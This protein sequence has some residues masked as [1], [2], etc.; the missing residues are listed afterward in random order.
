[1]DNYDNFFNGINDPSGHTPVY[2]TPENSGGGN[3]RNKK[4]TLI[5]ALLIVIAVIMCIAVVANVI[6]L[7]SMKKQVAQEYADGMTEAV[8]EE[9]LNAIAE[10]LDGKEISDDILAQ[11]EKDVID[12]LNTSAAAVAGTETVYSTV[13]IVATG[14]SDRSYGS[15]FLI[16][17]KDETT[18][19]TKRYVITNAHVV[20]ETVSE[21]TSTG[22]GW[23]FGGTTTTYSFRVRE[24][25]VCSLMNGESGTYELEE[26]KVGSYLEVIG[27]SVI[28][29]KNYT[30]L[31][32]LAILTF[33]D[34]APDEEKYPSLNISAEEADYGESIAIVGYPAPGS[35]PKDAILSLSTGIISA[36][37]H[38][39]DDW[40]AGTFYQTDSA[41]N[42]GNSGG[43][44]VN[45]K[46]EV[47][48]IVESKIT[49]TNIENIGYAVTSMTL[50][51]FM[52]S[53][54]L[55]PFRV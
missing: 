51:D 5:G 8:R 3:G 17:A 55:T 31:P 30:T 43:P 44:M 22:S 53:A 36:T 10:Y 48:G 37:A 2:H 26:V 16:T 20:L 24:D 6:V 47:V 27:S 18:G 15:G 45:N 7:A 21:T 39:L 11:I 40:G 14:E 42:G 33:K 35:D 13:Q 4:T 49:Y 9:Y 29:D 12:S 50:I 52:K 28:V 38:E 1:M 54:G 32:D 25:I 34:D 23:P 46:G 19:K 41:I